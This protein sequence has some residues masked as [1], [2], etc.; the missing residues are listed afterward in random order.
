MNDRAKQSGTD[1]FIVD[2]SDPKWKVSRY[3]HEW[4]AISRQIDIATGNFEIGGLLTLGEE[5]QSVDHIR[6]LMGDEVTL[7]TKKMFASTL[8]QIK[9]KLDD[10]L[11]EEKRSNDFLAGVPAIAAAVRRNQIECR[12]YRKDK[13]HAKAYITHARQEVVSPQALVG[14][15][16]FSWPGLNDNVELN[17]RLTGVEV[18]VLQK[19]YERFWDDAEDV[20]PEVLAVIERHIRE[21]SPFEVYAKSLQQ[22]LEGEDF[23]DREWEEQSAMYPRLA[24][25]QK[26]AYGAMLKKARIYN[27]AF[28]CDGVGLGKTFVGLTLIERLVE[29]DRRRVALFSPKAT[30][31]AVWKNLLKRFLPDVLYG[32][33]GFKVFNHTD[34]LRQ[35]EIADELDYVRRH[36]DVVIIDEAHHF[37]NKGT[38]GDDPGERKSRYWAMYD[39]CEGKDVYMLTATPVN[40]RIVDL[41]HMIELFSRQNPDHFARLGIHSLSGHFRR[42]E[43]A[44]KERSSQDGTGTEVD[45]P[46]ETDY[47]SAEELLAD[48]ELFR[49]IVVQRSRAYV[50]ESMKIAEGSDVVFPEREPPKV[51]DYQLKVVYGRLLDMVDEAFHRQ[52][53]LFTL[54]IYYPWPYYKGD[55]EQVDQWEKGR[56]KQVV[57][58]IRTGFLKRFESSAAA[59]ESSCWMLLKKLLAWV[60][61]H[62]IKKADQ[63]HLERW[64]IRHKDVLGYEHQKQGELFGDMSE[65]DAD[66]DFIA[67]EMLDKVDKLSPEDF[68]IASMLR[69]T[70]N[71]LDQIIEFLLE[72][73]KFK[74]R[75]DSKL[76][77]LIKI[78]KTDPVLKEH[79]VIIFSE[80]MTTARYL[81]QQL[82]KAGIEGVF[83]ID[84][85][86]ASADKRGDIITR[87]APY[88]NGSSSAELQELF[89]SNEIRV[90][91]S[92]DVLSEGLNLQD[93]TRLIN[94]DLHW[95]PVRLM[96][97]IGRV[98]RR[99]DQEIEARIL[100]DHPD[101]ESIRGTVAYWNF[102][103]PDELNQI[104]T[105]FNTVSHK[106]LRI[107]KTFGIEG[108]QLLTPDDDYQAL[109]IFDE[110]YEG[111]QSTMEKMRL[112]L[113]RLLKDHPDLED[114]LSELPSRV[115]SGKTHPD[116]G[117]KGVFFCY[118]MPAYD[119]QASEDT[120]SDTWTLAAGP[121]RWYLYDLIANSAAEDGKP[122]IID[123]PAA[124]HEAVQCEP[125]EPRMCMMDQPDLVTIRKQMDKHIKNTYLKHVQAPMNAP[126]PRLVAWMELS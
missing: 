69:D 118:A 8:N 33:V 122:V 32:G 121:C 25:Y 4:C 52:K 37:R 12:V 65:D 44:L 49:E 34:L 57:S 70:F 76:Q 110:A 111:E 20:T 119:D 86:R 88:Y 90:L 63:D 79:K 64:K 101:Q 77:A 109:R 93:A 83:E 43:K 13:F 39:L 82:K 92:T 23:S 104:L 9:A 80:F 35:G 120:G 22:L 97:R 112:E 29:R 89:G 99:M 67:P 74:P 71:D 3:L 115:F 17:V 116:D 107:S 21:Y 100:K 75:N 59:F 94:Y 14:S 85:S 125:A 10:S 96:Q 31:E 66:E 126:K 5:W 16:N 62:S 48:D 40:N 11:E 41:Q 46:I 24:Q 53:P 113:Q 102:L 72:L 19:W 73:K 60:E 91:I 38:K 7:R 36:Y 103:P 26:D 56:E 15:S 84:S 42:I 61:V 28:L 81:E 87:F 1:L 30:T 114:R 105:L 78:L 117:A 47:A 106:T 50:R 6:L 95:N 108:R 27:G 98:D 2:N 124:I 54:A 18:D 68:D 51:A 58:L 45:E 55:L 123:A